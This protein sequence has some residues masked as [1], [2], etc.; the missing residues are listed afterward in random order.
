MYNTGAPSYTVEDINALRFLFRKHD[1]NKDG[2]IS[3]Q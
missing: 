3:E 1:S 2:L